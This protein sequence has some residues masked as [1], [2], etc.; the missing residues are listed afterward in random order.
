[1][2]RAPRVP[3]KWKGRVGRNE[4]EMGMADAVQKAQKAAQDKQLRILQKRKAAELQQKL[5]RERLQGKQ[6][7]VDPMKAARLLAG[8]Q[9]GAMLKVIWGAWRIG[10]Q[11]CKNDR[12]LE[13]RGK[14]WKRSCIHDRQCIG[15]CNACGS[16][17]DTVYQMPFD[18]QLCGMVTD[19]QGN[20]SLYPAPGSRGRSAMGMARIGNADFAMP[21][22][23]PSREGRSLV[24]PPIPQ[25]TATP[26]GQSRSTPALRGMTQNATR[27]ATPPYGYGTGRPSSRSSLI[28][29]ILPGGTWEEATHWRTGAA[30]WYNSATGQMTL[31]PPEILEQTI[32]SKERSQ[33]PGSKEGLSGE[34]G[35]RVVIT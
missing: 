25:R 5:K 18:I 4:S 27:G 30:C 1:M 15:G 32:N 35:K 22:R 24:L 8:N 7:K 21:D 20:A 29:P 17:K 16:L 34:G 19:H 10:V 26:L 13:K 6:A 28:P 9:E 14:V 31:I 3:G 11:M 12:A 2:P 33:R 23:A